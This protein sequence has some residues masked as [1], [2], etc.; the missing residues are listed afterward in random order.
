MENT[1]VERLTE[2]ISEREKSF[3]NSE[4]INSFE[5]AIRDFDI[6]AE[7]GTDRKRGNNLLSIT[8]A[9]LHRITLETRKE[10]KFTQQ[11]LTEVGLMHF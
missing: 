9:H 3:P 11:G 4:Q 10:T 7:T 1:I 5:K 2:V 8:G 6:L